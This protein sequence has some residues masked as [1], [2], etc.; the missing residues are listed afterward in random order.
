M[1]S[2]V[3]F[4]AWQSVLLRPVSVSF[5]HLLR[6]IRYFDI[7]CGSFTC[8]PTQNAYVT[9]PT[10]VDL[11]ASSDHNDMYRLDFTKLL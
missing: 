9:N 7:L 11:F 3:Y 4:T 5:I 6:Y 1:S 2:S 8:L 10:H